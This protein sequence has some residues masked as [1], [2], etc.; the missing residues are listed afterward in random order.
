VLVTGASKGIGRACAEAFASE[1][2]SL[3]LVA[4]DEP[5]LEALAASL[6]ARFGTIA[7]SHA[8]DLSAPDGQRRLAESLDAVDI[9]VNNA[10]AI[11]GGNLDAVDDEKLRRGWEL[12][13]FGYINV[14]R[15][16]M[17]RLVAQRRGVIVNVIGAAGLRPQESYIAGGIA[18]A[19]LMAMTQ[20]LGAQSLR[21]GVRVVAVNPGLIL[22]DRMTDLLRTA[23]D[24]RFGDAERW[25]ELIPTDPAPGRAEQIADVVVFLASDRASHISGTTITVDGGASSR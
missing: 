2:C 25:A 23:A 24:T 8:I 20:A 11:P 19:G 15:M 21:D 3:D 17:P 5:A 22:T 9:V 12:K 4:R 7:R 14:C 1:G 16:L 10:G 6:D 18:N 13:V